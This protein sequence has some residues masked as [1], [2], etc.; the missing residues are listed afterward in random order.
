MRLQGVHQLVRVA[1]A[2]RHVDGLVQLLLV[3]YPA[4]IGREAR[5]VPQFLVAEYATQRRPLLLVLGANTVFFWVLAQDVASGRVALGAASTFALVIVA[6]E[7]S[8]KVESIIAGHIEL[9][10]LI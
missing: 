8:P 10:R 5:V 4:V 1:T 7:Y 3:R 6:S 9:N 2:R